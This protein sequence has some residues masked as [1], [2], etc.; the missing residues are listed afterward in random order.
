M[1]LSEELKELLKIGLT[2]GE[3]KVYLALNE[4]GST[5]VGPIVKKGGVAYSNVYDILNR[6]MEKGIVS[7]IIKGKTKYF[8]AASP[9]NLLDYLD[10]KEK[11]ISEQ[12]TALKIAI[13]KLEKLQEF[14]AQQDAEIFIGTKGLRS[15]YEK[16]FAGGTKNNEYLFLYMHE[17]K[18]SIQS[19]LFFFSIMNLIDR[20][21]RGVCN[22]KYRKISEFPNKAKMIKL[23][24]VNF[25]IAG[26][27]DIFKDK[28][29]FVAW[30]KPITG[31]LIHS[32]SI[33]EN[34]RKYF[35]T[36]WKMAK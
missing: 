16:L 32:Q 27:V 2:E 3:A 4:L 13:P 11:R 5:T 9:K 34:F 12:K 20:S 25:P 29:L 7:Y 14:T 21:A 24:Y 18:Y 31:I 28:I 35:E 33:T 19:D 10:K 30:D 15:A 26:N 36:V 22:E 8:Q 1:N 6:L 23:R 17:E